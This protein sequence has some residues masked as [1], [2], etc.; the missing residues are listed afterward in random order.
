MS[1]P[2]SKSIKGNALA[3]GLVLQMM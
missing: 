1:Y 3:I 2:F